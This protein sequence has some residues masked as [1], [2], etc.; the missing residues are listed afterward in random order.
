MDSSFREGVQSHTTHNTTTTDLLHRS[1]GIGTTGSV[2]G[3]LTRVDQDFNVVL[4]WKLCPVLKFG[5]LQRAPQSH[6]ESQEQSYKATSHWYHHHR[7]KWSPT[8]CP[9][10]TTQTLIARAG[11]QFRLNTFSLCQSRTW[12]THI[13]QCAQRAVPSTRRV[14]QRS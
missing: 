10:P 4:C 12:E 1:V 5:N 13:L 11:V 2:V 8:W 7:T 6:A 14:S 3:I 9:I